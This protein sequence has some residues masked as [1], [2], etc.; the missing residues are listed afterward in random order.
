MTLRNLL[1]RLRLRSPQDPEDERGDSVDKVD[2]ARVDEAAQGRN[3][4]PPGYVKSYDEGRP[5]H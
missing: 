3:E 2:D 5:P 1:R 4:F